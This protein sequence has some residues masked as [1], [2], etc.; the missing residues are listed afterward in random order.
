MAEPSME[1]DAADS[2]AP[3][4]YDNAIINANSVDGTIVLR[5]GDE[6]S[7]DAAI[8]NVTLPS[9][10]NAWAPELWYEDTDG[11]D[12]LLCDSDEQPDAGTQRA[13]IF[14]LTSDAVSYAT[15]PRVT[16]F[17]SSSHTD[18][19]EFI[20]GTTNHTSPFIKARG[21]TATTA[22]PQ[23]W[24]E[25]SDAALHTLDNGS[26]I[27]MGDATGNQEN[28]ALDGMNSYLVCSTTD[29]NGTPQYFSLAASIPD[30]ATTG[31][32]S[33]DGVLTIRYTYT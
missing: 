5:W 3:T 33:V 29:I 10:G 26:A 27:T 9:S 18:T 30:D 6:D 25:A 19:E 4:T 24:G 15:A 22:P 23:Y 16:V 17:D 1:L 20:D 2:A 11:T 28:C 13:M 31:V 7:A 14:K 12:I 8:T 32:D 21:Q